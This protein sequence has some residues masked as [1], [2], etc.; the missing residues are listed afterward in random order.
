MRR[1]RTPAA[2]AGGASGA[3]RARDLGADAGDAP[4]V[5]VVVAQDEV[6]RQP[7]PRVEPLQLL[8]DVGGLADVAAEQDGVRPRLPDGAAEPVDVAGGDEVQVEVGQ[9]G[10]APQVTSRW[11]DVSVTGTMPTGGPG[12][13]PRATDVRRSASLATS[14]GRSII[15][16]ELVGC[17]SSSRP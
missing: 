15:G 6:D 16:L 10:Q 17:T 3:Q 1:R 8:L 2:S 14:G 7:E 13:R 11:S 12:R 9:P 5:E 4:P